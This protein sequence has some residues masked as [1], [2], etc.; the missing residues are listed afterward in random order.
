MR[1]LLL[2]GVAVASIFSVPAIA[3]DMPVKMTVKAAPP[4]PVFSWTGCYVGANIG[5]IWARDVWTDT[6]PPPSGEAT[7]H[8]SSIVGGG[9]GG[10][11]YQ[12]GALV[13]GVEGMFDWTDAKGSAPDKFGPALLEND[14]YKW[15][16]T[17]TGRIGYAVDRTLWYVKAGGAWVNTQ[18]FFSNAFT[19]SLTQ[20]T[21]GVV[22]G[23][24]VEWAFAPH[25][26]VKIE[27]DYMDLGK[28][29][30]RFPAPLGFPFE[31]KEQIH[32]VT[33]GLNYRFGD[34][35]KGPVVAK[36]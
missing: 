10:C 35:G 30:V 8:A 36:Y 20:T 26:S 3:A 19:G 11:D 13:F 7:P 5:G 24:G 21:D 28:K 1:K 33:V 9:Q 32:T 14:K 18:H 2:S 16:S 27:Y 25:W 23:G 4:A 15:L 17:V 6:N 29:N 34:W 31:F 22:V 12:T